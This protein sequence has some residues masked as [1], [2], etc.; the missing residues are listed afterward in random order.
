MTR[1]LDMLIEAREVAAYDQGFEHGLA[2]REDNRMGKRARVRLTTTC[3]DGHTTKWEGET[4]D[5]SSRP[6][7]C[8]HKAPNGQTCMRTLSW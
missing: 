6:K 2:A 7:K 1:D 4:T 3:K 8:R 5:T